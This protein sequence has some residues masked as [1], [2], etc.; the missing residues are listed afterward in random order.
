MAQLGQQPVGLH[1]AKRFLH[2]FSLLLAD[3]VA[4]MTCR[5]PVE[6]AVSRLRCHMWREAQFTACGY[7]RADIVAL[8]RTDGLARPDR[9]A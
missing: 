9:L 1:P 6:A 8:V 3:P 7:K 5:P 4:S 2:P